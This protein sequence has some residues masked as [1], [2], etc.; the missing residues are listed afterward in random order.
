[1]EFMYSHGLS[2]L[3]IRL[4]KDNQARALMDSTV[5]PHRYAPQAGWVRFRIAKS[6]D[7]ERVKD[8]VNMPT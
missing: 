4:S 2:L 6:D 8:L 7:V 1:M 3:N 5:L